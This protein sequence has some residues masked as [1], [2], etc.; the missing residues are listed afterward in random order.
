MNMAAQL[1]LI[2]AAASS[3]SAWRVRV[4]A[5]GTRSRASTGGRTQGAEEGLGG[6][7]EGVEQF[8]P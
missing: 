1:G 3:V 5:A 6:L 8:D 2:P 7:V 4:A